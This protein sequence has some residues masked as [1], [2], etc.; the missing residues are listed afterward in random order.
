MTGQIKEWIFK[1]LLVCYNIIAV[2]NVGMCVSEFCK[3][4]L[5]HVLIFC[6]I[7]AIKSAI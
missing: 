5:L 4:K 6:Q 3:F 2:K 1:V 7:W